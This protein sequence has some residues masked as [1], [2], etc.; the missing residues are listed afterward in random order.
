MDSYDFSYHI[1]AEFDAAIGTEKIVFID[2]TATWCG[3]C[4]FIGPKFE[5]MSEEFKQAD[6]FKVDV[7]DD[8]QGN[9][10]GAVDWRPLEPRIK[11]KLCALYLEDEPL[12][13]A[14]LDFLDCLTR[15]FEAF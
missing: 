15:Q 10:N 9:C 7:E 1:Q 6:F 12:S 3:P 2:F 8:H 14:E 11:C 5:A 13:K 4:Q